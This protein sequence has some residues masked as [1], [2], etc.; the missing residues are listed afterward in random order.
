MKKL[1]RIIVTDLR[2]MWLGQVRPNCESQQLLV[3]MLTTNSMYTPYGPS[4]VA[5]SWA[6]VNSGKKRVS[7]AKRWSHF[8]AESLRLV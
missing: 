5:I 2:R 7:L 6:R 4:G 1:T 3:H 8:D